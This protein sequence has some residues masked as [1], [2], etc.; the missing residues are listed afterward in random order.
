MAEDLLASIRQ[1]EQEAKEALE[2]AEQEAATIKDQS[3]K[4]GREILAEAQTQAA[5]LLAQAETEAKADS[6][7]V[8]EHIDAAVKAPKLDAKAKAVCLQKLQERIIEE[9]VHR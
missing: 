2:S 3:R 7:K 6:A 1:C 8:L 4:R 5:A 9:L